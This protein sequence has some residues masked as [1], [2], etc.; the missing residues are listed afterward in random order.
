MTEYIEVSDKH[1]YHNRCFTH[2]VV[3]TNTHRVRMKDVFKF[4]TNSEHRRTKVSAKL[5]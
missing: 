1:Q 3:F 5:S 2:T 4:T